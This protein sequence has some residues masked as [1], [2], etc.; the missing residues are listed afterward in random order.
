MRVSLR[1]LAQYVDIA[2]LTPEALAEKLTR[3]GVA[4]EAV[5]RRNRGLTGAVIGHVLACAPHPQADRLRVCR[6][7]VGRGAPLQIVCGAPNVAAGQKVAVALPGARLPDGR[8]IGETALRGVTSQG[9]ILSGE[10]MGLP[11]KVIPRAMRD[12]IL[13]LADDAPVGTDAAAYLGLDDVVLELEL[14][15]NRADCFS[16]LGVAYEV[17][18]ILNRS[19]TLPPEEVPEEGEPAAEAV[20]VAIEAPEHCYRYAARLVRGVRIGPS[21]QWLQNRLMAAGI[22]PINNVV[23][24]TNYVMLEYGQPLHAFDYAA[25]TGGNIVVRLARNG[26]RLVTLDDEERI[27]DGQ[28]LLITDGTKAVGIAGVMGGA[29]SEV[30]DSTTDVLL[31]SAYFVPAS[32]RRTSRRLGI[33]SE[34]ALRFEKGVDPNRVIPALNRAARL[35]AELAGGRVAP[36][37]VEAVVRTEKPRVITVRPQRVN[38]LLGT[39]LDEAEMR[40][41]FQRLGFAVEARPDGTLA[42]T[43][44]TRRMDVTTEIDLVEEVARLV[45]YDNIPTTMIAGSTTAGRLTRVQALRRR[46]RRLLRQAGLSE[47]VTYSLTDPG[48][49]A[50]VAPLRDGV[51]PIALAMPMS[52]ERSVLRTTLVP[53]LLDA[54]AYNRARKNEDVRLFEIG[55]VFWTEEATLTRLPEERLLVAAALTGHAL[56]VH[57]AEKRQ[58][59]DFYHAKGV[60]EFLL[61][62]LGI[63]GVTFQPVT[64]AGLHPGR[65]ARVAVGQTVV[66]YVGQ[67]HPEVQK[68]WDLA[69]TYVFELDLDALLDLADPARRFVP[70]PKVPA[71]LRDLAVVVDRDVPA[72]A[73]EAVIRETGGAILEAVTLFDVYTGDPIPEGQKSVAFSLVFRDPARTLTDE[74]V[75][76]AHGRIVA[77]LERAYGAK[78]RG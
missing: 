30:R 62:E 33:R 7:D 27:L 9:M 3:S 16:M 66:G 48:R 38:D 1:W 11:D 25:L 13:V 41:V 23:D 63:G 54:V 36:G 52:E 45:G 69:E 21:P 6:V 42:V 19:V 34:A 47:A 78:L 58:K 43:V 5:E 15:P 55:R 51:R 65:T 26:E 39:A 24:V 56:P 2:D 75:A 68:A 67:L 4:V 70:L 44:P 53:H 46:V 77:A 61:K 12:G 60:V 28:T 72:A 17:A 74:E 71:V 50:R 14:T 73:L 20:R 18:A 57:W 37:V 40:A 22:R 8:T 35:L 76:A 32:V 10:E 49:A 29:N 59:V 31:E 64:W